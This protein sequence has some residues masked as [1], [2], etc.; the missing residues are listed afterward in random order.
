MIWWLRSRKV[1]PK[2]FRRGFD[3]FFF[4][5]GWLVWKERDAR[6]FDGT[7]RSA[8][9]LADAVLL[10]A[11]FGVQRVFGSSRCCCLGPECPLFGANLVQ[12]NFR[13]L[14]PVV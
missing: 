8:L 2:P 14:Y 1:V 3:T 9:E 13:S 6:T 7:Q 11:A 4:L 12:C 10:R 5:T